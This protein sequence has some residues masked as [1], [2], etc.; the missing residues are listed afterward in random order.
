[1]SSMVAALLGSGLLMLSTS[2]AWVRE[3]IKI[4][5]NRFSGVTG[6][7]IGVALLSVGSGMIIGL[8]ICTSMLLGMIAAWIVEPVL[9][10]N[11]GIIGEGAKKADILLWCMW[12]ATGLLV[13]GG[14]TALFLKWRVLVRTFESLRVAS[15]GSGDFPMRWIIGGSIAAS[16]ALVI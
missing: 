13:A 5:F 8:R 12:P 11:A 9:L 15:V 10:A 14:L 3:V 1:A 6:A 2:R 4:G 16:I 7:G